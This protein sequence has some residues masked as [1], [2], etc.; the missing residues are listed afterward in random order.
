M[1]QMQPVLWTKG[2]LLSPQHL[3]SQDRY[4]EDLLHFRISSVAFA[5]SG[6][7]RLVIDREALLGGSLALSDAAGIFPDGVCFDFPQADSAPPPKP[8]DDYWQPDQTA[9]DVY[10]GIPDDRPGGHNVAVSDR[11]G[12]VRFRAEVVMRRDE[13]TGLAEKPLQMAVKNLRLLVEGEAIDGYSTLR[14]ARAVRA[15]EGGYELDPH[16]IPP[17]VDISA[18]GYLL[19]IARRLVEILAA[20]SSML[21]GTRRQRN[22]SLADFGIADVAN[23]WLLYTVNTHFPILRHIFETRRGHPSVL[24]EAML[25]LAG[26]LTTFSLKHHPRGLP[27]YDHADLG[28]CFTEL[29]AQLRELL[30]TVVPANHA[31]LVLRET[32][33]SIYATAIDQDRYFA[34]PQIFLAVSAEMKQDE[35]VRKAPQLL[36]ISSADQLERLIRQA[37]PGVRF[38]HVPNPPSALPVKLN[39]QYCA[40]DRSGSDWDAIRMQRNL[41]VYA[42]S[43]FPAP[44][45]ELVVILPQER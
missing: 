22:Q 4:I 37:L 26:S 12:A 42:P 2:V 25:G 33:P 14:V 19:A 1:R 24:Y 18:S 31:T 27:A 16:F 8:L 7:S 6:F 38:Q 44:Q 20:K 5:P 23:F 34:A 43:D 36:K 28:T 30:E 10:L 41:A 21:S 32:Q 39:Y 17:L 45:F 3:Q 35:L 11:D 9:L 15:A 13:N 40:L 29:D